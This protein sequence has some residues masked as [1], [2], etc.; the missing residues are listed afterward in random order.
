MSQESNL[1]S[2]SKYLYK[3]K[4]NGTLAL[5]ERLEKVK[6]MSVLVG[7]KGGDRNQQTHNLLDKVAKMAKMNAKKNGKPISEKTKWKIQHLEDVISEANAKEEYPNNAYLLYIH[8]TGF[9]TVRR[10]FKNGVPLPPVTV[11]VPARPVISGEWCAFSPDDNKKKISEA[12]AAAAKTALDPNKSKEAKSEMKKAGE[13]GVKIAKDWFTDS[14]N[15]WPPNSPSTIALKT[16][17][18]S[19]GKSFGSTTPLIDTEQMR[20]AIKSYVVDNSDDLVKENYSE[21]YATKEEHDRSQP[22]S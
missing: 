19:N 13:L 2:T 8:S 16:G 20:K 12:L 15:N 14:R 18:G 6:K 17:K 1:R 11:E 21:G 5:F 4:K 7:I 9:T 3:Q 10:P 22:S